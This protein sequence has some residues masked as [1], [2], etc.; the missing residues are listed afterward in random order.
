M[1]H[2][3]EIVYESIFDGEEELMKGIDD[4]IPKTLLDCLTGYVV[5]SF[6]RT[7]G[8]SHYPDIVESSKILKK[9]YKPKDLLD[10]N[11]KKSNPGILSNM[12]AAVASQVEID[13][14]LDPQERLKKALDD[15]NK[16]YRE[17]NEK[18]LKD[19]DAPSI[20]AYSFD[21]GYARHRGGRKTVINRNDR[22]ASISVGFDSGSLSLS[23]L[24]SSPIAIDVSEN[25]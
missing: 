5:S 21:L 13:W 10:R 19:L 9:K 3:K 1:K 22:I 11:G 15:F 16:K 14:D 23:V 4:E 18:E 20:T 6:E 12:V 8:P 7:W 2:L 25:Q 24:A 17:F